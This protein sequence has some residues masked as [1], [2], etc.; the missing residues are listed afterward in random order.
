LSLTEFWRLTPKEYDLHADA[1][2]FK[3]ENKLKLAGWQA[4]NTAALPNMKRFPQ[5]KE[6]LNVEKGNAQTPEQQL[7]LIEM[8][9]VKFGGKDLRH[10]GN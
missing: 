4:W 7:H 2:R 8:L 1:Y 5:L 3:E 10:G 6:F 9:N